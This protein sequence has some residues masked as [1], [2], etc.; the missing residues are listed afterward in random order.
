M[1]QYL[2]I[3]RKTSIV[4]I[5]DFNIG[6]WEATLYYGSVKKVFTKREYIDKIVKS[7]NYEMIGVL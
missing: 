3:D 1:T 2:I 7:N 6:T 4:Y 5:M